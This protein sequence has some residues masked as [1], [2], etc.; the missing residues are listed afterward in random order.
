MLPLQRRAVT[1]E[2]GLTSWQ[3]GCGSICHVEKQRIVLI[4]VHTQ[5]RTS[6]VEKCCSYMNV[7]TPLD[8]RCFLI[9]LSVPYQ[10]KPWVE[11]PIRGRCMLAFGEDKDI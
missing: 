9:S 2:E 8:A 6:S 7:G 10:L 11:W 5:T 1:S 3:F 4:T